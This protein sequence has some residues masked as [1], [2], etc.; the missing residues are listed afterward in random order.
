MKET[1][2]KVSALN[3][4]F[5]QIICVPETDCEMCLVTSQRDLAA[6]AP[7]GCFIWILKMIGS[8]VLPQSRSE[9]TVQS[10]FVKVLFCFV[11]NHI[12]SELAHAQIK[13]LI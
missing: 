12:F 3:R 10:H 9:S 13:G 7:R 5:F 4:P 11:N 8:I 6:A 1:T 2:Q